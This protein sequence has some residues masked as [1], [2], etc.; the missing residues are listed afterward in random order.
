MPLLDAVDDRE[1]VRALLDDCLR[2]L[3]LLG[4]LRDL[5][6]EPL[7]PL[8]VVERDGGLARE[9]AEEIAIGFAEPSERAVDVGIEVA[10]D[11]PLRDQRRDDPRALL[12]LGRAVGVVRQAHRARA[13]HLRQRGR[14]VSQQRLRILA[15]WD[16]RARELRAI[17]RLQHQQHALG[18]GK[19]GRFVDQEFVQLGRAAQ[20]VQAQPGVD[21]P[22]EGLA[23]VRIALEVGGAPLQRKGGA[24]ARPSATHG[25]S[26]GAPRSC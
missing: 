26:R 2:R 7:R 10:Q 16:E 5:L 24:C 11:L 19:L 17:G 23:Q 13:A 12:E 6:F 8:R 18:A 3:Q 14:D 20:L 22:L 25:R 4:A 1:L 9:H 21:E 15:A